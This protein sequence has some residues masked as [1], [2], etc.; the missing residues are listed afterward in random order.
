MGSRLVKVEVT[1]KVRLSVDLAR[2]WLR[3]GQQVGQIVHEGLFLQYTSTEL[4][5]TRKTEHEYIHTTYIYPVSARI[6]AGPNVKHG[7]AD[8]A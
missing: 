2:R 6:C 8:H 5:F 7:A 4:G 3:L 1:R